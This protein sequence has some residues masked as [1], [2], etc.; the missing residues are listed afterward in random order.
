MKKIISL[1][2]TLS[3]FTGLTQTK[4]ITLEEI[5]KN[6]TFTPKKFAG[7][8]SMNDGLHYTEIDTNFNLGK[9]ELSTGKKTEELV[10]ASEL[11]AE[12]KDSA[13]KI[14]DYY[15]SDDETKLVL[16]D[17]YEQI[18]RHS[19]T[20]DYYVFDFKTRKL[21][22]LSNKGK[23]MFAT[24]A[25]IGNKVA[26][27]RENNLFIKDLDNNTEIQ[28]TKDGEK[29]KIKNGWADWVYEEEFSKAEAFFLE[30]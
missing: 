15:F 10:K 7:F 9:Y 3:F 24:I 30:C 14:K 27:V 5:W 8:N 23:Q 6:K 21:K 29:N 18:Y 13:I 26:F 22:S 4:Q 28:I 17:K 16:K 11:V 20:A 2:L 12:G 1:A 25:P 19:G